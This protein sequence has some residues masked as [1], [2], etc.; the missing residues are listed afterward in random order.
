MTKHL[1]PTVARIDLDALA[2]NFRVVQ[3]VV[4][5]GSRVLAPVK[6]DAYGHGAVECARALERAGCRH[7]GVAT[8]LEGMELRDG[9]VK[10]E[11]LCLGGVHSGFEAALEHRL[12]PMLFSLE[13]AEEL[14]RVAR[15]RGER[16]GVHLK[17][18][19][20][21]NRLGVLAGE[22]EQFVRRVAEV[23]GLRVEGIATHFSDADVEGSEFSLEQHRRLR[24]AVEVVRRV[25][26]EPGVVHAANSAGTARFPETRLDMVRV[27]IALYGVDTEGLWGGALKPVMSVSSEL[28]HLKEIP[29]GEGVSYGRT[30]RSSEPTLIATLPVGYADG[31]RRV[32]S[33][34]GFVEIR[35]VRCPL[36]GNICMDLCMVDVTAL[37]GRVEVGDEAVLLGGGLTAAELASWSDTIPY[38]ILTGFSPRVPRL[39]SGV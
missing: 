8:V 15:R 27:G 28:I 16:V 14:G 21:M 3:G 12:T 9:G 37:K 33:N 20:G 36:R 23:E 35:G 24:E 4:G 6:A 5:E 26:L 29:A 39:F 10:G 18:D 31:Y 17:V 13:A 2:H 34:V 7:F 22:W 38:E 30:W 19:T 32:L 11:I 1:R 25:G